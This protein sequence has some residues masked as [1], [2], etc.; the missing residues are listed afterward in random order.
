MPSENSISFESPQKATIACRNGHILLVDLTHPEEKYRA[1]FADILNAQDQ[2]PIN[3]FPMAKALEE[4][5]YREVEF[6][7]HRAYTDGEP[8][9]AEVPA[10]APVTTGG[11][12]DE[13]KTGEAT[14]ETKTGSEAVADGQTHTANLGDPD[15]KKETDFE[16]LSDDE[17]NAVA[18]A[19]GIDLDGKD[20]D[21]IILALLEKA[22]D[23]KETP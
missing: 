17:L 20:R 15:K 5:G 11:V 9:V 23:N 8:F 12:E 3:V 6:G 4:K 14:G 19:E 21:D 22:D 16:A 18:I 1:D 10:E 7:D 2:L 13:P